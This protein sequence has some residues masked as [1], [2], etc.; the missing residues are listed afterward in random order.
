VAGG[1]RLTGGI[2]LGNAMSLT[3]NNTVDVQS[4]AQLD[5]V[6]GS[7][8]PGDFNNNGVVDGAD[9]VVWRNAGATDILPNDDTPGTVDASDYTDFRSNFGGSTLVGV[10]D[11]LIVS[12]PNALSLAAGS[13][14]T[15]SGGTNAPQPGTYT[16]LQYN[17]G[18]TGTL[19]STILNNA[20]G[21]EIGAVGNAD[22]VVTD[23]TAADTFEVAISGTVQNRT[24]VAGGTGNWS[25]NSADNANWTP[26]GQPN[27]PGAIGNFAGS[28]AQTVTI[29]D[30]DKTLGVMNFDNTS[31]YTIASTGTNRLITNAYSGSNAQINVL[32][33]SH[34]ISAPMYVSKATTATI[35]NVADNLS[36][37]GNIG[38]LGVGLTKAGPGTMDISGFITAT[39]SVTVSSGTLT[40]SGQNSYNGGTTIAAGATLVA[41]NTVAL[42][43]AT[44]LTGTNTA[45]GILN[46]NAG[47]RTSNPTTINSGGVENNSGTTAGTHTV[48]TGGIENILTGATASGT[49]TVTGGTVNVTGTLTGAA[50]VNTGG[51]LTG[52]GNVGSMTF[53]NTGGSGGHLQPGTNGTIG[54]LIESTTTGVVTFGNGSIFDIDIMAPGTQGV[55]YDTLYI[56]STVATTGGLVVSTPTAGVGGTIAVHDLSGVAGSLVGSYIIIDYATTSSALPANWTTV[57][58][59]GPGSYTFSVTKDTGANNIV[60][61]IA[62]LGSGSGLEGG[63]AVPEPASIGLVAIA[64]LAFAGRR[65]RKA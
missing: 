18:Y 23:N 45:N 37:S 41:A 10:S 44:G 8:R 5:L 11:K 60:L 6:I 34:T 38:L 16:L 7:I 20:S 2:G 46:V 57:S 48:V 30:T 32:N 1:A 39:G 3:V 29:T 40:L 53:N 12:A 13:L 54:A 36:I 31:G 4:G 64:L 21:F 65:S 35:S 63:G 62:A 58:Y 22:D 59:T 51:A 14:V 9:Y 49:H 50:T 55:D 27:G 56:Q 43:S 33:G 28:G 26:V 25:A 47:A 61:N 52:T 24:W 19:A 15:V 42:T 17:T